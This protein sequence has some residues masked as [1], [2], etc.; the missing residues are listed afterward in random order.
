MKKIQESCPSKSADRQITQLPPRTRHRQGIL[1]SSVT[2]SSRSSSA[3]PITAFHN[4]ETL[5]DEILLPVPL[6]VPKVASEFTHYVS[7]SLC[8]RRK[9]L[10]IRHFLN[11]QD[12]LA[13]NGLTSPPYKPQ[14]C[15][16]IPRHHAW[17]TQQAL[18]SRWV[19]CKASEK[20]ATLSCAKLVVQDTTP[21]WQPV[22]N[23][24]QQS[25]IDGSPPSSALRWWDRLH[26]YL[27]CG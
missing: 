19:D 18:Q 4:K 24:I 3:S 10:H 1:H 8:K 27:D 25:S 20:L 7:C 17:E 11:S 22:M 6:L 15:K 9:H 14:Y 13:R 26:L 16:E 2:G 21:S 5:P 23:G 12:R